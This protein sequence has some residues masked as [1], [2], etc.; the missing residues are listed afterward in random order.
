MNQLQVTE[1]ND[2]RVLTTQQIAD[3]YETE[4]KVISNNF[5]RNKGRYQEGKHYICLEGESKRRF[6]N[7]H[8]NEDGSKNAKF[9]YLWTEKGALLH[10]KSLNTDKAWEAYD[11]L[12]DTYFAVRKPLSAIEQLKLNQEAII[13]VN[14]KIDDINKDLQDFK[15]DMP[16]L[17]LECDRITTAVRRKGVACLVGKDSNAY[18]DHSLRGKIYSDIHN[19]LR[20]EFGVTSYKAIKRSQCDTAVQIINEYK[21]PHVLKEEIRDCNA[22]M[23]IA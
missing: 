9:L 14:T 18:Q 23:E 3:S 11:R 19:Q 20:R 4:S 13:E 7:L 12:V 22:Q 10:A 17:A 15:Q 16:L 6:L 1:Y 2:I 21:L 5:N 8:Q